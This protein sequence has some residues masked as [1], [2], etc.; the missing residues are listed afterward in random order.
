MRVIDLERAWPMWWQSHNVT[1]SE[2][3][4]IAGMATDVTDA[5]AIWEHES[6][7]RDNNLRHRI[8]EVQEMIRT[9][10]ANALED[11][12]TED[13]ARPCYDHLAEANDHLYKA[14]KSL[15]E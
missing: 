13:V 15:P 12:Y 11:H 6:W 4:R 5:Q 3:S 8:S 9:E 1:D 7:W 2:L 14:M 10:I